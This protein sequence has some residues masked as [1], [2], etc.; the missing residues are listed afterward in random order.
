MR[1]F[2]IPTDLYHRLQTGGAVTLP[3]DVRHHIY[4]VLRLRAGSEIV[5]GD[6]CGNRC[7]CR[8]D[9]AAGVRAVA[10][11][12]AVAVPSPPITLLQSVPAADKFELVLQKNTELGVTA[13]VPLLSE[14]SKFAKISVLERKRER[15]QRIMTEAARQSERAWL[16]QLA[17]AQ[18]FDAAVMACTAAVKLLLWE[19]AVTPLTQALPRQAPTSLALL[20]GPEGGFSAAEAAMA[21]QAGFVAVGLG[22][23][24]LRSETAAMAL[25]AILQYV[26]GDLSRPPRGDGVV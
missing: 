17:A 2:F 19:E 13:V 18:P 15:W 9:D 22:P 23:R 21:E 12:C 14:R 11:N 8:L 20:V 10:A 24:I 5:I 1:Q 16:P 3:D 25:V 6:G 7:R 26:Y 4:K